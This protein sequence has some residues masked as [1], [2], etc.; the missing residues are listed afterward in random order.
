MPLVAD[1]VPNFEASDWYGIVAPK[2]TP[3]EFVNKLDREINVSLADPTMKARLAD[4]GGTTLA[5][6][7]ADFGRLIVQETEKW[8][9]VVK[10]S[11]AKPD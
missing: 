6:S 9:K 3:G 7:P 11:G 2:N 8:G 5:G 1:F 10:F 4:M